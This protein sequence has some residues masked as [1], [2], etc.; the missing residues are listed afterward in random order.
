M[1][2]NMKYVNDH[3]FPYT[4]SHQGMYLI[5][6]VNV[7]LHYSN[8]KLYLSCILTCIK[9]STDKCKFLSPIFL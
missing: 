3:L 5:L 6:S 2:V 8:V 7:I 4:I 9:F 1:T